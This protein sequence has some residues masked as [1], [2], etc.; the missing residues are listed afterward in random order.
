MKKS[1][2][3]IAGIILMLM[4]IQLLQSCKPKPPK[5]NDDVLLQ[6]N[7]SNTLGLNWIYLKELNIKDLRTV[8]S[9]DVRK[10]GRH[11][12]RFSPDGPGF[13]IIQTKDYNFITLLLEPGERA[14]LF[15]DG[16]KMKKSYQI[17][18]SPGS[19]I[20]QEYFYHTERNMKKIDSLRDV[21][22][23]YKDTESFIKKRIELDS[24]YYN[25]YK[26]QRNFMVNLAHRNN[27]SIASLFIINQKFGPEL[28][29]HE[30]TD[31]ELFSELDSCLMQI[32]P[33]NKH[34]AEHHS[35]ISE[36]KRKETELKLADERLKKGN[37]APAVKLSDQKGSSISLSSYFGK[38]VL[39]YFWTAT[40]G[41]ARQDH[42]SMQAFYKAYKSRGLEIISVSL[43][44]NKEL[45]QAALKIDRLPWIN[46]YDSGGMNSPIARLFAL[47][48]NLPVY[49]LI[50]K[51]GNMA[52][53]A[54][55][56]TDAK[57]MLIKMLPY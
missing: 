15:A 32:Y 36:L 34:V 5:E 3:I 53:K 1:V 33:N 19:L 46:T 25:I 10:T 21:F 31:F 47:R 12:F 44:E 14:E 27:K 26:E 50:D 2:V 29:L 4:G 52:G 38:T 6:V 45:W 18:G 22:T 55:N 7:F 20:L 40:T 30:R 42:S 8:D 43:D 13:Y 48:G 54:D 51:N 11:T 41:K 49:Y 16:K 39:L 23:R 28:V 35:R 9:F 37:P 56:F 24:A 57:I 17:K